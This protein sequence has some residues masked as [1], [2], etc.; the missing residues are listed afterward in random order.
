[1]PT[2][3]PT[4]EAPTS[5]LSLTNGDLG[6]EDRARMKVRQYMDVNRASQAAV[7]RAASVGGSTLSQF[8]S[9]SYGGDS[10]A[11]AERLLSWLHR[12]EQRAERPELGDRDVVETSVYRRIHQVV[13]MA[14]HER[15]VGVVVGDA[16]LGKTLALE[17]YEEDHPAQT[18]RIEVGPEYSAKSLAVV[19]HREL[20]GDG[21]GTMFGLMQE[22]LGALDGTD[23]LMIVDQAEIL[24]TR[25]LELCRRVHDVCSLGVVLA[26]MPKLLAHLQGSEAH[27]KQ[28]YSR[29]GLKAKV[30]ELTDEDLR[31]LVAAHAPNAEQGI[32]ASLGG[33]TRNT[34]VATKLLKRAAHMVEI[35]DELG[36][37][38]KAAV[39][40]A[41]QMLVIPDPPGRSV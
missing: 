1:M 31:K 23:K 9:G 6:V 3:A 16:G 13:R 15:D 4:T 14:H 38:G 5:D 12:E 29:V 8:L 36:R 18:L 28:L 30:G 26:G 21:S 20:G 41:T 40:K 39:E 11:V 33:I 2:E 27:L 19:L 17:A 34:R 10:E 37:V 24:P 22:V 7:A 35:N 32:A 25:G